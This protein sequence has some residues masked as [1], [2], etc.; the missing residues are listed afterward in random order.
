MSTFVLEIINLL[1]SLLLLLSFSM[2]W[3]RRMLNL[4]RLLALQGLV[5]SVDI[6]LF[7]YATGHPDM[8]FS[9]LLTF[10]LKVLFIPFVL[11]LL[12][13]KLHIESKME[14]LFKLPTIL[15]IGVGLV[16]LAFNLSASLTQIEPNSSKVLAVALASVFVASLVMVVKRKA[17]SQVI[18]FLALENSLFFVANSATYGMPFMVELGIAFDVLVGLFIF[19]IFFFQ[20]RETFDSFDIQH[21]EK[22]KEE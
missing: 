1:A 10:V 18:G 14:E 22:L 6:A 5:L 2:L 8:Y 11:R 9:A 16:I 4:I 13:V 20:L 21:L 12:L 17:I 7:A 19:G 15:L 3:Q